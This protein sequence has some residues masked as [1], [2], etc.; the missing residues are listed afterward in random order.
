MRKTMFLASVALLALSGCASGELPETMAAP[1]PKHLDA[2]RIKTPL[3]SFLP[4]QHDALT[5]HQAEA[6]LINKC[7]SDL[8]Y[9][10]NPMPEPESAQ[11]QHRHSEFIVFPLSQAEQ[12][13]YNP[14]ESATPKG[15]TW[16][17]RAS[18]TQQELMEGKLRRYKGKGVPEGGCARVAADRITEG[19]NIPEKITGGGVVLDRRELASPTG[20][21]EAHVEVLRLEAIFKTREDPRI[22]RLTADWSSCMSKKGHQYRSPEDA[23]N[24][25]R[26]S[27]DKVSQL[28]KTTA[29]ADMECKQQVNYLGV[30]VSVQSGYELE[31]M[32]QRKSELA[33]LR[34][35]AKAWSR[36][37][38]Q[39]IAQ[40]K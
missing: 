6:R 14:P 20:L 11:Q 5:L 40:P 32:K 38:A 28:E 17:D 19:T 35:N 9:T 25:D 34:S 2:T 37:A 1:T 30:M 7:L 33:T 13:G 36:N 23:A 21:S 26:W 4:S 18:T 16:D 29:V 39:V 10:K 22:S 3:D 27:G 8:G 12:H 31:V 15:G 24:D